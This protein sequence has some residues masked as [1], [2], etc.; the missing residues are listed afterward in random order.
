MGTC[1]A[2]QSTQPRP[3][4]RSSTRPMSSLMDRR[5]CWRSYGDCL[6]ERFNLRRMRMAMTVDAL[7]LPA[8]AVPGRIG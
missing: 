6:P 4:Q 8:V 1:Y 7:R 3:H 2:S 5:D